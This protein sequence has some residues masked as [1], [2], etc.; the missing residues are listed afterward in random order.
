MSAKKYMINVVLT[1]NPLETTYCVVFFS[2]KLKEP[3]GILFRFSK[4]L[5]SYVFFHSFFVF[6]RRTKQWLKMDFFQE[7]VLREQRPILLYFCF[8]NFCN[9]S[10]SLYGCHIKT[11]GRLQTT[12]KSKF[13]ILATKNNSEEKSDT[14]KPK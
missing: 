14:E 3:D 10:R 13:S 7:K 5:K 2:R 11:I 4:F 1:K 12:K 6:S 8:F 9:E